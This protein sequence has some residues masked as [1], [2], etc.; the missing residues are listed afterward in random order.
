VKYIEVALDSSKDDYADHAMLVSGCE[1]ARDNGPMP[2]PP[3]HLEV[4]MELDDLR[5]VC[6]EVDYAILGL[7]HD[8]YEELS[9]VKAVPSLNS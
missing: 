8:A 9:P 1:L 3:R 7:L 6:F 5:A 2:R 4:H